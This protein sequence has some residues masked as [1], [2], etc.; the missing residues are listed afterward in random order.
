VFTGPTA[1]LSI[2]T[3]LVHRATKNSAIS[4]TKTQSTHLDLSLCNT[5][6]YSLTD[7]WQSTKRYQIQ[8]IDDHLDDFN[9]QTNKQTGIISNNRKLDAKHVT[10]WLIDWLIEQCFTSPPTQY[11]LYGRRTWLAAGFCGRLWSC[12]W[13][14]H[15]ATYRIY[16]RI[17][18]KIYH[19]ILT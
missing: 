3:H 6:K 11:R 8:V 2:S 4:S 1:G 18:R 19:K 16:S 17:S 15:P 13:Q 12:I 9:L 10:G 14:Y 5:I 7:S